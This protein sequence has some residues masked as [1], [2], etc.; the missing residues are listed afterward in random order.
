MALIYDLI[1]VC[2]EKEIDQISIS[3]YQGLRVKVTTSLLQLCTIESLWFYLSLGLGLR[4]RLI[5][6]N[7]EV[8]FHIKVCPDAQRLRPQPQPR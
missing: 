1:K 2:R 7:T 5:L 3:I 8:Y 4:L 6:D